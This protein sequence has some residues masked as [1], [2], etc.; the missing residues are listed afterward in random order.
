MVMVVARSVALAGAVAAAIL[1]VAPIDGPARANSYAFGNTHSPSDYA[2]L[3]LEEGS[4]S[5]NLS[6]SGIQGWISAGCCS[7]A[8]VGHNTSYLAGVYGGSSRNNFFVFNV[9]GVKSTVTS[10]NLNLYAGSINAELQYSLYG[11]TQVVSE[12]ADGTSPHASLYAELGHG[13]K[14]GSF[15]VDTGNSLHNIVF[16]LNSAAGKGINAAIALK[17]NQVAL[18]GV[19]LAIPELST[20]IM[21]LAGFAGLGLAAAGRRAAGSVAAAR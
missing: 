20:W 4:Q 17:K 3:T 16:A 2:T 1:C 6:S 5:V 11:A 18:G 15:V 14:Y 9:A 19:A 21:M 10:A 7:N 8:G 12:L 13:V